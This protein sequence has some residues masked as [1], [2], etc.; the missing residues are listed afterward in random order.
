M[1]LSYVTVRYV[2]DESFILTGSSLG[3]GFVNFVKAADA[4]KA[5]NTLNGLR[6]QQKTIKV[7]NNT[8]WSQ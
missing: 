4:D 6:M 1:H 2:I 5:I 3:Y 7:I 8:T